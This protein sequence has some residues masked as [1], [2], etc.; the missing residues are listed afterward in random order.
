MTGRPLQ[1]MWM[2]GIVATAAAAVATSNAWADDYPSRPVRLIVPGPPGV[3]VDLDA[4]P[5]A[6]KIGEMLGQPLVIE[7][8]PAGGG[9]VAME[10]TAKAA[11]DGYTLAIAGV[12]ALASLPYLYSKPP[13]DPERDFVPV[14]LL[15]MLPMVVTVHSSLGVNSVQDLIARA[16]AR[17]GEITFGS[18][19]IGTFMH[20]AG[21]YFESA[22]H[23]ELR[24][25]PYGS[26]SPFNDL[27]GG[28]V[29]LT[30]SGIAP[31]IGNVRAGKL[32][33]LAVSSKQRVALI[34]EVPTFA[35]AGVPA[36]DVSA[37]N[38]LVAP[39]GT[40]S[41]IVE[42]LNAVAAKAVQAAEVKDRMLRF[43]GFPVGSTPKEFADFV[44]N[45]RAKW[46]KLIRE[47]KLHLD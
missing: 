34:P 11:P 35:E 2:V 7:N 40:P 41:A 32:K 22:A 46:G 10:T 47:A 43:G 27:A 42:R 28:H 33:I 30:F 19:G 9:V 23:V 38:G 4:R 16:K 20:L 13:Y 3:G 36:Y 44:R 14:I 5:M 12:G 31:V 15:Q 26:Q 45:E 6:Q 8:R 1:C 37:W 29:M 39:R 24:H 17:P 18:Q 21:E 25:V